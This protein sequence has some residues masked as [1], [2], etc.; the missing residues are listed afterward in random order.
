MSITSA[1]F[2]ALPATDKGQLTF[3]GLPQVKHVA[4]MA[5]WTK[6]NY[7]KLFGRG[8]EASEIP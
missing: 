5:T 6:A 7:F 2:P 4:M 3:N 1:P 8:D